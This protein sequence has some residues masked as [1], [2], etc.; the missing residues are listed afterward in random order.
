MEKTFADG[1][2]HYSEET[3]INKDGT[4]THWIVKTAPM[5][6]ESGEIVGAMEMS[7]DITHRKHLEDKLEQSEKQYHAIFNN[8]PSPVFVLDVDS[9]DIL[10]C[11]DS[12][13]PVYGYRKEDIV[14]QSFLTFF[15]IE[16]RQRY[17][18]LLKTQ[19]EIDQ[20][21]HMDHQ[22]RTLLVNI[23]LSPSH[24]S[25][26]DVLLAATSDITDRV[27]AELK[28]IQAGKMA[29]LGE[30]ATG[31]AHELNQPLSVI[32]TASSYF[33]RKTRRKEAIR[34]DILTTM[35][36][37]ID[38]HVDRASNIINHLRQFGR[39]AELTLQP[40]NVNEVLL[41]AFEM[42]S[43]QLKLRE[44]DVQWDLGQSLP[45]IQAEPGRLEQVFINLL[46]NGRDA[47]EEKRK[48]ATDDQELLKRITIRTYRKKRRVAIDVCD[49]GIGIP[50]DNRGKIFE[51]FF[52][53][54][55]VGDGTGI[56][57]SIS[58]GIVKDFGGTIR[59]TSQVDQGACFTI[60]FPTGK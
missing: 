32:K 8:I 25:G 16:E 46:I 4:L 18:H 40:V 28:L 26:H 42:F 52:T 59:V 49:S 36:E 31:V 48:K 37:E 29:T 54:K 47:I 30:M 13:R 50:K 11:N 20:A 33:L 2:P 45:M 35:A 17:D 15:P 34:E 19:K 60:T 22:G 6:D 53:T 10:D 55:K 1:R 24:Y 56:G 44:I 43:Q 9:F 21:R 41:K 38:S 57:L 39:K 14:G 27:E 7:L 23:R 3:G 5:K 58:Y 51:P 12:I